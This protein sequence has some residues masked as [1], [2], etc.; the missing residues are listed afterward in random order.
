[1]TTGEDRNKIRFKNWKLCLLWKLPFRLHGA[2]KRVTN[3]CINPFVPTFVSHEHHPKVLE[4]LHLLQCISAHLQNTALGRHNTSIFLE[5]IFV[6][7]WSHAAENRSNASWRPCWKD[8]RMQY[9]FVRKKQK[10]HPE[11]PSSNTLVEVSV[12]V[13]HSYRPGLSKFFGRDH[14]SYCTTVRGPDTLRHVIFSGYVTFYQVN[15]FFVNIFFHYWQNAF[16]G[17]VKWLRTS[18]L[19]RGP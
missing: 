4:R 9:Q 6:R 7:F 19:A 13:Y 14:I 10:V 1:M 8:Q 12:T 5:L 11:V 17:P 18:D 15:T 3:P 16:C 2:V